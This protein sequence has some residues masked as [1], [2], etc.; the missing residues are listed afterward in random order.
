[1]PLAVLSA[2]LL[3]PLLLLLPPCYRSFRPF[4]PCGHNILASLGLF[5]AR[6]QL[7]DAL[8]VWRAQATGEFEQLVGFIIDSLPSLRDKVYSLDI[9]VEKCISDYTTIT[10]EIDHLLVLR[11]HDLSNTHDLDTFAL[12]EIGYVKESLGLLRT[13]LTSVPTYLC[14]PLALSSLIFLTTLFPFSPESSCSLSSSFPSASMSCPC[15][16]FELVICRSFK[17]ED[18]HTQL[19]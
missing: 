8:S 11:I 2:F 13:S 9:T 5:D 19:F 17:V 18:L 6:Y 3:H 1:M 16:Y 4:C 15:P 7:D 10:Q 14:P 12:T